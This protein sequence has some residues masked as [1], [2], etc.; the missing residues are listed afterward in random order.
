[1]PKRKA[2]NCVKLSVNGEY[3]IIMTIKNI[4]KP[5]QCRKDNSFVF[6]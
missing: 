5:K 2:N 6:Q 1:M 4:A 3:P